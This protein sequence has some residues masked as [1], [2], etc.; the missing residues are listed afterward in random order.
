MTERGRGGQDSHPARGAQWQRKS[1]QKFKPRRYTLV[2]PPNWG[3]NMDVAAEQILAAKNMIAAADAAEEAA[4]KRGYPLT[5]EELKALGYV[6]TE[7]GPWALDI[8]DS[9]AIAIWE[10]QQQKNG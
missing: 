5:D 8:P 3:D 10:E 6:E 9:V 4:V 2:R 1:S 7:G